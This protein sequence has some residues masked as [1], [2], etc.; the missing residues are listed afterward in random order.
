M[1]V[2]DDLDRLFLGHRS[3]ERAAEWEAAKGRLPPG[4]A[5]R[6]VVVARYPFGVFVDV[7]VGFPGL[8]LVV[9]LRG[10]DVRPYTRVEAYPEVGATVEA[11]VC[12]WADGHRQVGLTQLDREPLLGETAGP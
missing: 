2:D 7:G 5:V 9:R 12:V 10:A 4:S 3:P 8:I 11:R 6:G 1:S